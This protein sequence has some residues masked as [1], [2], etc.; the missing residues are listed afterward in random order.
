[1]AAAS[2]ADEGIAFETS[3]FSFRVFSINDLVYISR[4]GETTNGLSLDN[5]GNITVAQALNLG[6]QASTTSHAVR[7]DRTITIAGTS[8]QIISSAG[9]QDFT[10]NRV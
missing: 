5:L 3:G 4:S 1:M 6:V 7:A 2:G 8:N 10:A 9:A